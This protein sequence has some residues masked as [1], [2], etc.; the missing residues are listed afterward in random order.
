[1]SSGVMFR[2]ENESDDMTFEPIDLVAIASSSSALPT[3][4]GKGMEN[5]DDNISTPNKPNIDQVIIDYIISHPDQAQG[6]VVDEL[7]KKLQLGRSALSGRIKRLR[8]AGM[9]EFWKKAPAARG[10]REVK[11]FAAAE[12]DNS[13][14]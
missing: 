1:M 5:S 11:S 13:A 7:Q 12:P 14:S 9:L 2:I 4:E 6:V 10:K 8:E 3:G